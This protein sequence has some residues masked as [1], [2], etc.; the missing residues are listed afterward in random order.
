MYPSKFAM[1]VVLA[2]L[3]TL[4]EPA[5][6]RDMSLGKHSADELKAACGKIGGSFSQGK[7]RYGCGTDCHGAPG[8]DC[9]VTCEASG[10]CIAQVVGAR[11]PRTIESALKQ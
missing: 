8:T 10:K 5:S 3:V 9:I 11:R 6:A 4:I 7:E 1:A 2:G